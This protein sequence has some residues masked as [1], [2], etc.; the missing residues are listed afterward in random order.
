MRR[1]RVAAAGYMCRV[2]PH[3]RL[4]VHGRQSIMAMLIPYMRNIALAATHVPEKPAHPL[5]RHLSSGTI[6]TGIGSCNRPSRSNVESPYNC[7]LTTHVQG[8][9]R[10]RPGVAPLVPKRCVN[11]CVC[12]CVYGG[13]EVNHEYDQS[14]SFDES[15]GALSLRQRPRKTA[16]SRR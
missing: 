1:R 8:N 9:A 13:T 5:P 4:P 16:P 12:V 2:A 15:P 3:R 7:S 11:E 6:A 14:D 10:A